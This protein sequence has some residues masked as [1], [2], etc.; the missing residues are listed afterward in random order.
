MLFFVSCCFINCKKGNISHS[1]TELEIQAPEILIDTTD[2]TEYITVIHKDSSN[3][4]LSKKEFK[5]IE[6]LLRISVEKYNIEKAKFLKGKNLSDEN[7]KEIT[8]DLKYYKRQYFPQI[9]DNGDKL[10]GIN[11]FCS[12]S[13]SDN[14]KTEEVQVKDGG[15]CYFQAMINLSKKKIIYFQTNGSS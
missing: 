9:D 4:S 13:D 6:S 12:I 11:C 7:L 3:R 1:K 14:W 8:I 2:G 10:V 15:K 5:L